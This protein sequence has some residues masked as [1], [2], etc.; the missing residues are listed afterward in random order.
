MTRTERVLR[1]WSRGVCSCLGVIDHCN[2]LSHIGLSWDE[3]SVDLPTEDQKRIRLRDEDG[4]SGYNA[5]RAVLPSS[6]DD[7]LKGSID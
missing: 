1:H 3:E 4:V 2:R 7:E 5:S 6:V